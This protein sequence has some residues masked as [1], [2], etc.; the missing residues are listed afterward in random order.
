MTS[1]RD[2]EK[3]NDKLQRLCKEILAVLQP[4]SSIINEL[5]PSFEDLLEGWKT[6][7]ESI[8][9]ENHANSTENV[10]CE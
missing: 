4:Q 10:L 3:R 5:P 8:I 9:K 6:R 7:Y 2:L 1:V